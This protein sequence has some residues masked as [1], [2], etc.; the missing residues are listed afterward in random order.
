MAS[1][2]AGRIRCWA[3]TGARSASWRCISA[4]T[5]SRPGAEHDIAAC[6]AHL[7]GLA[8]EQDLVR[9]SLEE[10][11]HLL[12]VALGSISQG[13]C[14]FD[15]ARRLILANPRYADIYD[16]DQA[17]IRPG[18][19]LAE[20]VGLRVIAGSGPAMAQGEYLNWRET[21]Q[22]ADTA[23]QSVVELANGKVVSVHHQPMPDHGWVATHED[24]TARRQAE[25]RVLHMARH[26]PLTGLANRVLLQE[27]LEQALHRSRRDGQSCAVL[28]LDL[29]RF[30]PVNDSLGH[31]AGDKLLKA[32]AGRLLNCV[33][34][35]DTVT[36]L[37]GD[38]FAILTPDARP[39][40]AA[41]AGWRNG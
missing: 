37:G 32:V 15:G 23:T 41:L 24:I 18:M 14:F 19:S 22:F 2:L 25:A 31:P 27:R 26:D 11:N 9:T 17:A 3:G 30:K 5:A 38:E 8:I 33:R 10:S 40:R 1:R 35:T 13:V 16:L 12:D 29:D 39:A 4:S 34:E 20:I 6:C 21:V 36:R 28:C 7:A